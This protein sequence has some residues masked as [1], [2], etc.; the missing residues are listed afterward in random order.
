MSLTWSA[1]GAP[2]SHAAAVASDAVVGDLGDDLRVGLQVEQKDVVGL[3]IPIDDHGRVK[4]P[5]IKQTFCISLMRLLV[6]NKTATNSSKANAVSAPESVG[7]LQGDFVLQ[8]SVEAAVL[9]LKQRVQRAPGSQLH[10]QDRRR[11]AGCQQA[12]QAGVTEAAQHHQLLV[13][14]SRREK[15]KLD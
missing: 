2:H 13:N 1:L 12:Y 6:P 7:H 10:H 15:K 14:G 4:V 9:V 5:E 3:Q 8:L 11:R